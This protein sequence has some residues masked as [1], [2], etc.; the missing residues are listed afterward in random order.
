MLLGKDQLHLN[1]QF[2][3]KSKQVKTPHPNTFFTFQ[4]QVNYD[5]WQNIWL[6]DF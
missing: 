2:D 6:R 5:P 1:F 3:V 4:T